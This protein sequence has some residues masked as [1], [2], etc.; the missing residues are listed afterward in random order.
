MSPT[1][2]HARSLTVSSALSAAIGVSRTNRAPDF[3][4]PA[5]DRKNSSLPSSSRYP[6]LLP[7]QY[8]P[9]NAARHGRARMSR[10]SHTPRPWQVPPAAPSPSPAVPPTTRGREGFL[11]QIDA[12]HPMPAILEHVR[13]STGAARDIEERRT[14]LLSQQMNDPNRF[15]LGYRRRN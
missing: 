3:S 9:S 6:K 10:L 8:A 13:Q 4:V 1:F 11:R 12:S 14:R 7:K 15:L 2:H 5:T